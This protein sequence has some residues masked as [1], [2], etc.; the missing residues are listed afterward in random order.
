MTVDVTMHARHDLFNLIAL[1]LV[2]LFLFDYLLS[3]YHHHD[4]WYGENF[5]QICVVGELYFV[6]DVIWLVIWP[7]SV[8]SPYVIKCHHLLCCIGWCFPLW[9]PEMAPYAAAC[10]LVEVNTIFL[11]AKRYFRNTPHLQRILK[12]CFHLSWVGLRMINYPVICYLYS[13][14]V[15]Q[16]YSSSGSVVNP[17][18]AAMLMLLS[19][20]CLNGR[21][22]WDLYFQSNTIA[23]KGL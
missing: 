17:T 11:I 16:R 20:T 5:L 14:E 4:G 22:S 9:W 3:C 12:I 15:Q 10:L 8:A 1:P 19:L 2:V 21:W 13:F 23:K 6:V 18:T 7:T